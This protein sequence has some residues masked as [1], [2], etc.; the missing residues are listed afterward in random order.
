MTTPT[1]RV[2]RSSSRSHLST[3]GRCCPCRNCLTSVLACVSAAGRRDQEQACASNR[4]CRC[5]HSPPTED[6]ERQRRG[7]LHLRR[8]SASRPPRRAPSWFIATNGRPVIE[9]RISPGDERGPPAPREPDVATTRQ[10]PALAGLANTSA[11]RAGIAETRRDLRVSVEKDDIGKLRVSHGTG[12]LPVR[13]GGAAA[14]P[15]IRAL[16]C[17]APGGTDA[18]RVASAGARR[19]G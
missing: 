5:P 9:A 19:V 12:P 18:P 8:T 7:H 3:P 1:S 4:R 11:A 14:D 13:A 15:R 17:I 6:G 16:I 2:P 10:T